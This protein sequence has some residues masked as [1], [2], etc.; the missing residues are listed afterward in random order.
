MCLLS[1][2]VSTGR[3][4]LSNAGH[5][6]PLVIGRGGVRLIADRSPLLG[7]V[8]RPA[9]EVEFV[10]EPDDTVV[11]YTDGL[12]ETRSETLDESLARLTHAAENV[13]RDLESF[14]TRLLTEVGP[15]APA[16][17]IAMVVVR[18]SSGRPRG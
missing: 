13:E 16:D 15:A 10:L 9:T 14:A 12:I 7:I 8:V 11:L 2:D 6:P 5:P 4:R 18:R 1:I 3:T 17:D